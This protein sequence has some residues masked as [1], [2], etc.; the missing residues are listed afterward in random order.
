MSAL[1]PLTGLKVGLVARLNR[2]G[3]NI[4]GISFFN[5][6]DLESKQLELLREKSWD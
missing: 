5:S 3:G 2:P 1:R 4:T 6:A